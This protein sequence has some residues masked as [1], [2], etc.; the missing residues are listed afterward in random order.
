VSQTPTRP[1]RRRG[2]R[3]LGL[4]LAAVLIAAVAGGGLALKDNRATG[5]DSTGNPLVLRIGGPTGA[6]AA[7]ATKLVGPPETL[8][9]PPAGPGYGIAPAP[10]AERLDF[11]FAK[12]APR[13]G[14]LWDIDTGQV[15]W[16]RDPE[17]VLA[18]ASVTKMMTALLVADHSL[19]YERVK[20]TKQALAYTGSG[21]GVLPKKKTV[22]LETLLYG[23]LLPS[24]NDAAI[25]LAQHVA[26][27]VPRFVA[28]MNARA[29][30]L[31][32]RCTHYYS[33]SGIDNRDSSCAAD[34][35]RLTREVLARPR[36]AR[37][38]ASRN[39]VLPFPIKG[40]KLYLSNNNT[41]MRQDY[42]G[43]D[44]VK[45]GFTDKAGHCLVASVRRHG[46]RLGMV[47]L[48]SPDTA[49]Q[50]KILFG[51]GFAAVA[52]ARAKAG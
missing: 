16:S 52:R 9:A 4:F 21:V 20:I 26:G 14:L 11:R 2:D 7:A 34:L 32:L 10:A 25:A 30:E 22:R 15:L 24:G 33:P 18:I 17:R 5:P 47:L 50:G 37:I 36:L 23:L 1:T 39:A 40:G 44:G 29:K 45:T 28:M 19:P 48:H 6:V 41:L 51:R 49:L 3:R 8:F 43:V 13:S 27:T 12:K 42:P 38:V 46:V 35:A 31:G